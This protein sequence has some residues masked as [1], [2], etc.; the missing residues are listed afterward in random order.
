MNHAAYLWLS[1]ATTIFRRAYKPVDLSTASLLY[2]SGR[3]GDN[4]T[5]TCKDKECRNDKPAVEKSEH[6]EGEADDGK[7]S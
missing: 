1:E 4:E 3:G 6:G 7:K 2:D 5:C